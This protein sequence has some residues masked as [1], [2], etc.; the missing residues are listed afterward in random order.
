MRF[1]TTYIETEMLFWHH[2]HSPHI[3]PTAHARVVQRAQ[4]HRHRPKND[5]KQLTRNDDV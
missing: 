3:D 5:S 4:S 1:S 2:N